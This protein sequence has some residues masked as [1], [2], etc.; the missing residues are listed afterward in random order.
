MARGTQLTTL[1]SMLKAEARQSTS[2]ALGIDKTET[3][4]RLLRRHQEVLYLAYD[5]PHLRKI[6]T[7]ALVAGS[8]YYDVPSGLNFE[9]IE[10]V[11]VD[12]N[13]HFHVVDR[14]IGFDEYVQYD[15]EDDERADPVRR[16]DK[17]GR[18]S[19]R[20]RV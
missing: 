16:W 2:V 17:I 19:C 1:L 14:G 9:R 7:K 18:A 4:K 8:R 3:Y 11:R 10:E 13:S 20:E 12:Y 15:S 6:F 5:W